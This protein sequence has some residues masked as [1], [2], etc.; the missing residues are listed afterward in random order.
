MGNSY[1]ELE[2]AGPGYVLLRLMEQEESLEWIVF[3]F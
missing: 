3:K 2:G 1:Q